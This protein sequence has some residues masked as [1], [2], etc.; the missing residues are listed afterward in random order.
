M[1]R[2]LWTSVLFLAAAP[3][4]AGSRALEI[5]Y[6][7]TEGGAATLIVTPAGES[8][9]I[10]SGNPGKRDAERIHKVAT[11]KAKLTQIDHHVITH[12]HTDH[13][14]GVER[15]SQLMPI[16]QYYHHG[17]PE[18]LVEDKKDFPILIKAFKAAAGDRQTVLKPGDVLPLKQADGAPKVELECIC[19]DGKVTV[20]GPGAPDNP[21]AKEHKPIK[22]APTDNDK[23]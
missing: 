23:S 18:S 3:A 15:L 9:L 10:D 16:K 13:F 6:C 11:E 8:V 19:S 7:D 17:I 1:T 14:G 20:A 12:W 22:I 5:W 4:L 21:I 2:I